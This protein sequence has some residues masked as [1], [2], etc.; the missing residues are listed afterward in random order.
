MIFS[1]SPPPSPVRDDATFEL[2]EIYRLPL[3]VRVQGLPG[4]WK[5]KQVLQDG[6]DVTH[7]PADLSV[8]REPLHVVVT[9]RLARAV[10]R[11]FDD[12][13]RRVEGAHVVALVAAARPWRAGIAAIEGGSGA[14]GRIVLPPLT[15]G[16]YRFIVLTRDDVNVLLFV[17]DRFS[18]LDGIG[19]PATLRENE[20]PQLDVRLARLP[21]RR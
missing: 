20:S 4:D 18:S 16:D 12:Q 10:V 2:P 6:R 3:L 14:D 7:V 21:E 13:G 5:V 11:V 19:T 17:P 15:A 9:N 8:S 1:E